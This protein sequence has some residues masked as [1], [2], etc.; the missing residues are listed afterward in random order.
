MDCL[1]LVITALLLLV[2][3]HRRGVEG[4]DAITD[5]ACQTIATAAGFN[6]D[7]GSPFP[8]RP[9]MESCDD[10]PDTPGLSCSQRFGPGSV[11]VKGRITVKGL[12][13]PPKAKRSANCDLPEETIF[14]KR[15]RRTCAT[16]CELPEFDCENASNPPYPCTLE[17]KFRCGDN[18][19]RDIMEQMCPALCG[20][21]NKLKKGE[22]YCRDTV[23]RATCRA[24]QQNGLCQ[25]CHRG[26]GQGAT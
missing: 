17:N 12:Q 18:A 25:V 5:N 13:R 21:C 11:I 9:G 1:L 22:E 23:S 15:C 26:P 16:C 2:A 19:I 24:N 4:Q 14:V 7:P 3:M 10:E 20:T 6:L 8:D